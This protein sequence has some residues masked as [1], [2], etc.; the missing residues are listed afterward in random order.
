MVRAQVQKEQEATFEKLLATASAVGVYGRLLKSMR[1]RTRLPKAR[2]DE[3]VR[4]FGTQHV[5][6]ASDLKA[7]LC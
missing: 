7:G 5:P 6:A 2:S 3:S 4:K 1:R